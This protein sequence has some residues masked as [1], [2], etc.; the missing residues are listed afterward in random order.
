MTKTL[1]EMI[2][3]LFMLLCVLGII[4][5]ATRCEDHRKE[6]ASKCFVETQQPECWK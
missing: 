3:F 2:V 6:A 1:G 5:A 4:F